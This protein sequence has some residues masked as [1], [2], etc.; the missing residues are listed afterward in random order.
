MRNKTAGVTLIE[1]MVT[2]AVLAILASFAVPSMSSMMRQ[3]ELVSTANSL[4][5]SITIARS[6][7]IKRKQNVILKPSGSTWADGWS[8]RTKNE[9]ISKQDP[10]KKGITASSS[11][12]KGNLIFDSSGYLKRSNPWGA[13]SGVEF[14]DGAGHSKIIK[15]KKSGSINVKDSSC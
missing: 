6:E 11:Q 2:I 7:A 1:L 4:S 14:C 15:I 8:I 10:I 12:S 5:T 3:N 9:E 13:D